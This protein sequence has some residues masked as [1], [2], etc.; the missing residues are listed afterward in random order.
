MALSVGQK[1]ELFSKLLPRLIDYAHGLGFEIRLRDLWRTKYQAIENERLGVGSRNSLHCKGLAI[2]LYIR[3]QGGKILWATE[4]YR[5]LG[6]YW[7]SID[8]L[9]SWGGRFGDGGHFSIRHGGMQ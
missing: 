4:H 2:D 3:R 1:Q 6:E 5:E 9:C 8:E 7:E